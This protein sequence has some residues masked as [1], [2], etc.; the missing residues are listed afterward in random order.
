MMK[1]RHNKGKKLKK[2]FLLG[3]FG[4]LF[5]IFIL[6]GLNNPLRHFFSNVTI[7]VSKPFLKFENKISLNEENNSLREKINEL[8]VKILS[9]EILE[10]ENRQLKEAVLRTEGTEGK[11]EY[12]L[13]FT[14]SRP[15]VSP[16]DVLLIDIGSKNG[17]KA[18]MEVTAYADILIGYVSEVFSNTS[19]VK[20]ISFPKNEMNAVVLSSNIPVTAIGRGGGNMEI[21]LPKEVEIKEGEKIVIPGINPLILGIIE[22][23]ESVPTDPF[24]KL[25]LRIPVNLQELRYVMINL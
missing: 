3:V 25:L 16:Y 10:E 8:E 15:P 18:G 12:I 17:I 13:G 11:D 5:L 7:A 23:I 22:K 1:F 6:N 21:I 20:L 19:K 4:A 24:Q 9:Y 14:L 2:I